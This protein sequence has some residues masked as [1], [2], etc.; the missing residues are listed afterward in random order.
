MPL[1]EFRCST[2]G[3]FE[4][5]CAIAQ[6]EQPM[7]CPDCHEIAQRIFSPPNVNLNSG[8]LA[9]MGRSSSEPRLVQGKP[10]P[11]KPRYQSANQGRP[12]MIS[13]GPPR[14]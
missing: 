5:F 7:P 9:A 12:W 4:A 2:C 10:E 14:Y 13:H 8:S 3:E 11:A 1:Y 6:R